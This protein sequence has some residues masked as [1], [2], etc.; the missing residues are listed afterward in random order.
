[1]EGLTNNKMQ[2]IVYLNLRKKF[3]NLCLDVGEPCLFSFKHEDS[4]PKNEV[5]HCML[6]PQALRRGIMLN[7]YSKSR[8]LLQ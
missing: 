4:P 8:D 1:M 2:I 3:R 5:K 6:T 7:I